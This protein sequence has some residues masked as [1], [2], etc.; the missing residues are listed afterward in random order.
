[1]V[2]SGLFKDELIR[3]I[4]DSSFSYHFRHRNHQFKDEDPFGIP[5]ECRSV[6]EFM[7]SDTKRNLNEHIRSAS[8][9]NYCFSKKSPRVLCLL[10]ICSQEQENIE[11]V[12]K[13]PG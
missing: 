1:M 10:L 5:L 7:L 3:I 6:G 13:C 12:I 11:A 8:R 2:W 9:F 4:Q